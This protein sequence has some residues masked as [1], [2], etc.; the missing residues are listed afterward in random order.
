MQGDSGIMEFNYANPG[1]YM[2]HA[3]ITDLQT[4]DG[5]ACLT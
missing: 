4:K 1:T 3:H 2:F 5:W